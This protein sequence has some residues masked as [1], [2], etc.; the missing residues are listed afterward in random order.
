M[1][2]IGSFS[3]NATI[4]NPSSHLSVALAGRS[5]RSPLHTS[6]NLLSTPIS[7][8]SFT[9]PSLLPFS[10][11]PPPMS[12]VA[13]VPR[14]HVRSSASLPTSSLDPGRPRP[15]PGVPT[16]HNYHEQQQE[17]HPW[18]A[19]CAAAAAHHHFCV[20]SL[21]AGAWPPRLPCFVQLRTAFW[22]SYLAC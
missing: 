4:S 18:Q 15:R 19:Y 20:S 11:L 1:T 16:T 21:L 6:H 9:P 13:L 8:D 14:T 17:R 22:L 12:P 7:H 2:V 5:L 3:S 10:F